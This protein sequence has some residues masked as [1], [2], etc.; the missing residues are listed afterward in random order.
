MLVMM[1]PLA[2]AYGC[3]DII[4]FPSVLDYNSRSRNF[5]T[6]GKNFFVYYTHMHK[7]SPTNCAIML[8]R[9]LIRVPVALP[10]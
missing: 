7:V 3:T 2:Y 9:D 1:A 6:T 4:G 8:D 5:E 10:G